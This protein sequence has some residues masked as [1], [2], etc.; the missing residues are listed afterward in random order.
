MGE[1]IYSLSYILSMRNIELESVL[2]D[3]EDAKGQLSS[4]PTD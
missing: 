2:N 3:S 4:I 1:D